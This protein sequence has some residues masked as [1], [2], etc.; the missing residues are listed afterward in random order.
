M[1]FFASLDS[2]HP[3]LT[4]TMSLFEGLKIMD[5]GQEQRKGITDTF[6]YFLHILYLKSPNTAQISIQNARQSFKPTLR[7]LK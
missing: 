4:P 5:G 1:L 3:P 2:A 7:A 6:R